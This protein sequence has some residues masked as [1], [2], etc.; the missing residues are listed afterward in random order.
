MYISN[1]KSNKSNIM[2]AVSHN[3]RFLLH[4]MDHP[5]LVFTSGGLH[6]SNSDFLTPARI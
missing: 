6:W 2:P 1:M 4:N 3:I 5:N